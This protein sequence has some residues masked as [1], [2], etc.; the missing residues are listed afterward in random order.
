MK[1]A[2]HETKRQVTSYKLQ[3]TSYKLQVTSY[4]L[5]GTRH[6]ACRSS[7]RKCVD[8][9]WTKDY[10]QSELAGIGIQY[11]KPAN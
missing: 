3:V 8:E 10:L 6:I 1:R 4:K 7:M 11:V 2:D 9:I 5:Q